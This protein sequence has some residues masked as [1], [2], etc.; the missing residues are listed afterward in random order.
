MIN[1]LDIQPEIFP[2]TYGSIQ[3]EYH[4]ND[5]TFLEIEIGVGTLFQVY[6][7]INAEETL[8]TVFG[9]IKE[10]KEIINNFISLT[11]IQTEEEN[12]YKYIDSHW[13][14]EIAKEAKKHSN[15]ISD[16]N[17]L[18]KDYAWKAIKHLIDFVNDNNE[19]DLICA[20]VECM[21]AFN[22]NNNIKDNVKNE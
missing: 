3:I 4:K 8:N 21:L 22:K 6:K 5:D 12:S 14:N 10:I 18:S 17:T 9:E 16:N 11:D 19:E 1:N 7:V 15:V 13:I 20:S 2:T